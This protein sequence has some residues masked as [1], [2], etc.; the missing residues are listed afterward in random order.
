M[1]KWTI[2]GSRLCMAVLVVGCGSSGGAPGMNDTDPD[3]GLVLTPVDAFVAPDAAKP[4]DAEPDAVAGRCATGSDRFI[5]QVISFDPGPCAGFGASS[6][7]DIVCGPPEGAGNEEGSTDV[8]SLGNGGSIVVGFGANGIEDG[9][10]DDFVVFENPFDV[11][12]NPNDVYMEQGE[13]SVS[14]DGVSWTTFPCTSDGGAFS[15][16]CAG[17]HAVYSNLTDGISPFDVA[18]AGGDAFDLAT[19]GVKKAK[20]VRIRDLVIEACED[21]GTSTDTPF[22]KDGFDLDAIAIVNPLLPK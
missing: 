10:G 2:L 19:L 17:V 5:K 3:S 15:G 9:P 8:V 12:G 11:G 6:M 20:Y 4:A 7:P 18:K 13:V 21:A 1:K 22:H 16:H 14:E